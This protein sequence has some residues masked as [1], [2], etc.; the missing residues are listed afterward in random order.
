[1][2]TER[3]EAFCGGASPAGLVIVI[4]P[5]GPAGGA[6][7][8]GVTRDGATA[9]PFARPVVIESA[10]AATAD[11]RPP[12]RKQTPCA[13]LSKAQAAA[14]PLLPMITNSSAGEERQL[15]CS[16]LRRNWAPEVAKYRCCNME[17]TPLGRRSRAVGGDGR[18]PVLTGT[19]PRPISV[20]HESPRQAK[21]G[22]G[23]VARGPADP[24]DRSRRCAGQGPQDRHLRHR[25]PHLQLGRVGAE[26]DPDADDGRPRIFGRDRRT[27]RR[28]AAASRSASAC[29]A[30]AT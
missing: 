25:H 6:S 20:R 5:D 8:L 23:P 17:G 1:M 27:R 22:A 9:C 16:E 26:D 13:P 7:V 14:P 24:R 2:A 19:P 28:R 29:R 11:C 30:K 10:T 18:E 3:F 4:A 12:L 21:A 15:F